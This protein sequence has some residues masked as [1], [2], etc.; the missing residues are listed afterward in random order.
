MYF[1]ST[2]FF[3]GREKQICGK[4][5]VFVISVISG[6]GTI[7]EASIKIGRK[8]NEIL[9]KEYKTTI[10][11]TSSRDTFRSINNFR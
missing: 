4:C 7:E 6:N 3:T 5:Y 1:V 9:H 10:V 2:K 8:K 11:F